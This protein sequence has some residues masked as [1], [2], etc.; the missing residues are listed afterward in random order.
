MNHQSGKY[1]RF[2]NQEPYL[3]VIVGIRADEKE[4][5]QRKDTFPPEI[6]IICGTWESNRQSFG[7]QYKTDF[8]KGTHIRI[9]P[10]LHGQN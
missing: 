7:N 1:E 8:P 5:D 2:L 4:V 3:G 10:L 9:H 6:K